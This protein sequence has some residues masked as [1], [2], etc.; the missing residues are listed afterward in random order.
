MEPVYLR[1]LELED[2]ERTWKWHNDP[3]LYETLQGT[4][5]HVS[6]ATE[7]DWLRKKVVYSPQELNLAICL[8][9]N[10]EHIGNIYVRNIDWVARHGE[11]GIFLGE[12]GQRSRGYGPAAMRLLIKHAFQDLGLLRLWGFLL[13]ENKPSNRMFEKCGFV[14]EGKL[15]K[16]AFKDG[17]FK[18]VLVVGLCASDLPSGGPKS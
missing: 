11:V 17:Q 13:E 5:H 8:R 3:E 6:R 10:S 16:H 4:F 15:R 7:E 12:V 9:S 14:V 1:A 18:D 2:L